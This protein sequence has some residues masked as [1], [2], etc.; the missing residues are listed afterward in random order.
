MKTTQLHKCRSKLVKK[1]GIYWWQRMSEEEWL[2]KKEFVVE[3][4]TH[5]RWTRT[6]KV[7]NRDG[8]IEYVDTLVEG[9]KDDDDLTKYCCLL[10]TTRESFDNV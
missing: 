4:I 6:D 9:I 8:T 3:D 5:Q 7:Q 1:F 2:G 10:E